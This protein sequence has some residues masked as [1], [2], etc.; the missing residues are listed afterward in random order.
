M[1]TKSLFEEIACISRID[2]LAAIFQ[3]CN[4]GNSTVHRQVQTNWSTNGSKQWMRMHSNL[5]RFHFMNLVN[6]GLKLTYEKNALF[7]FLSPSFRGNWKLDEA[8]D[9]KENRMRI[10]KK[11]ENEWNF[12]CYFK[13]TRIRGSVPS[14]HVTEWPWQYDCIIIERVL[15]SYWINNVLINVWIFFLVFMYEAFNKLK[16]INL[17]NFNC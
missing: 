1:M 3:I 14:R 9:I 5:T 6:D 11:D 7:V 4:T 10:L 12:H 15:C 8:R 2:S 16:K 13:S 17:I